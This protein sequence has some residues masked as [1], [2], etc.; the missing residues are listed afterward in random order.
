MSFVDAINKRYYEALYSLRVNRHQYPNIHSVRCG[1]HFFGNAGEPGSMLDYGAGYGQEALH[2]A[3]RGYRVT[4]LE[5]VDA[6]V[7]RIRELVSG[8]GRAT[9][10]N[11][12]VICLNGETETLPFSRESFDF[13][14]ASQSVHLLPG[15]PSLRILMDEWK[16]ILKPGGCLMFSVPGPD[17]H[18]FQKGLELRDGRYEAEL[19][20]PGTNRTLPVRALVF[21]EAQLRTV[22]RGWE[23]REIGWYGYMYAGKSCW[24][25]QVLAVNPE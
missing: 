25:W 3:R 8:A 17:D 15:Q 7:D 23:V 4:A 24:W 21:T 20:V 13:I 2:F 1:A 11:I 22:C 9:A 6:A 14:H 18:F 5:A 12:S 16:R 10:R 19:L